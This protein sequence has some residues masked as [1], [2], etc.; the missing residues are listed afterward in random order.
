MKFALSRIFACGLAAFVLS[1]LFFGCTNDSKEHAQVR[2][3]VQALAE[4]LDAVEGRLHD[5]EEAEASRAAKS[6]E[7]EQAIIPRTYSLG[8][9]FLDDPFYGKKNSPVLVMVF[10]DFQC[11]PC[12]MFHKTT[13]RDI[14]DRY[15][16]DERVQLV[17]RDFPLDLNSSSA[18]AAALAH[19]AGESGSYWK[20]F[21][22]F[23]ENESLIDEG[24]FESLARRYDSAAAPKL[25]QCL[26]SKKYEP[27]ILADRQEGVELGAKGAPGVFV[28][29]LVDSGRYQGVFIRGAQP[30]ALIDQQIRLHLKDP[31]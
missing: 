22:L 27:E 31:K 14:R 29:R 18:A 25:L 2:A 21:D 4:K 11:R 24:N 28:G 23:V 30:T 20:M 3:E 16:S 26:E 15:S 13:F 10:S 6:G 8:P 5:L 12:R 1:A 19:C 7:A 17:L 9:A